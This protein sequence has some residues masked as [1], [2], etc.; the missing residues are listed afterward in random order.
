[1]SQSNTNNASSA[2]T[3]YFMGIVTGASVALAAFTMMGQGYSRPN[4]PKTAVPTTA[5]ST[6]QPMPVAQAMPD[7]DEFF[8]TPGNNAN[9]TARLWRRPAGSTT[10]EFLGEHQPNLKGR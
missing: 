6:A 9:S 5:P 4:E 8:V 7:R 10:L 2:R 1:M 3:P